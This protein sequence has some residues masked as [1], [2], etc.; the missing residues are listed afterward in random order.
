MDVDLHKGCDLQRQENM[1]EYRLLKFRS[2]M[3]IVNWVC[4]DALDDHVWVNELTIPCQGTEVLEAL[5]YDIDVSCLVKWSMLW[6]S[7]PTILN[8]RFLNSGT[9]VD[10]YNEVIDL[11][12]RQPS[13][14]PSG[15]CT[16]REIAF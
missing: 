16:H 1:Q 10:K 9:I 4:D 7:S 6:F 15:R 3:M 11:E 12:L 8:R 14:R 5:D 2:I 13:L